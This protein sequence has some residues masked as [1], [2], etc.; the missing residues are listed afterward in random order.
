MFLS[1]ACVHIDVNMGRR[2][3]A[4]LDLPQLEHAIFAGRTMLT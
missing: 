2:D 4:D 3:G 1:G